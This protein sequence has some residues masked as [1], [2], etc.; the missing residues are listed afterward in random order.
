MTNEIASMKTILTKFKKIA[1]QMAR[2]KGLLLSKH[3]IDVKTK[4]D[5]RECLEKQHV[6]SFLEG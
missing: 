4:A 1:Y 3:N 5:N 6:S 2:L